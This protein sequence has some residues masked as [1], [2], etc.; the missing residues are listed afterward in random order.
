MAVSVQVSVRVADLCSAERFEVVIGHWI[1][2]S[3][4]QYTQSS[5]ENTADTHS[6]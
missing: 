2:G 1:P 3:F 4:L 5:P 6:K